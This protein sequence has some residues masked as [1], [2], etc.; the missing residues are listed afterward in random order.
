MS[1]PQTEREKA[2]SKSVARAIADDMAALIAQAGARDLEGIRRRIHKRA[3]WVKATSDSKQ[4]QRALQVLTELGLLKTRR[5]VIS[6]ATGDL[7]AEAAFSAPSEPSSQPVAADGQ[8]DNILTAREMAHLLRISKP[9]LFKQMRHGQLVG[10]LDQRNRG[11]FPVD[12]MDQFGRVTPGI[13][14]ILEH[15]SD[16]M[17]AWSWLTGAR[18]SLD[19]Q[20]PLDL[21]K[22]GEIERAIDAATGQTMGAFG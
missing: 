18:H 16:P 13:P 4:Q 1:N 12:Q 14:R 8:F 15:F 5:R 20:T 11:C 6:R 9:T 10:W 19:D 22:R 3:Q 7:D 21:L 2:T 17:V